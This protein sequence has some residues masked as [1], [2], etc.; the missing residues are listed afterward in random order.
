MFRTF[1]ETGAKSSEIIDL[2]WDAVD[3]KKG[4]ITF[5]GNKIL[6]ERVIPIS[7]ELQATLASRRPVLDYVFTSIHDE[8]MTKRKISEYINKFKAHYGIT[9]KWMYFDLRHSFAHNFMQNGGSLEKLRE[10]LGLRSQQTLEVVYT[11][12]PVTRTEVSSPYES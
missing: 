6:Q 10:M 9:D 1:I 4:T 7:K 5:P 12:R 3:F 8:K 2:K 11:K